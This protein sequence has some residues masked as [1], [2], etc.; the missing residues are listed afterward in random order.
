M[1]TTMRGGVGMGVPDAD[2]N[3]RRGGNKSA[4]CR[5]IPSKAVKIRLALSHATFHG[6][7]RFFKENCTVHVTMPHWGLKVSTGRDENVHMR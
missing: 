2:H 6:D 7:A 1:H 4:R 3:E 5:Q